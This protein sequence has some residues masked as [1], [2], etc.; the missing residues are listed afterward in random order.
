MQASQPASP[1]S[2]AALSSVS[3]AATYLQKAATP[4]A[5]DERRQKLLAGSPGVLEGKESAVLTPDED[6]AFAFLVAACVL[7]GGEKGGRGGTIAIPL[8]R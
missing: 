1:S 3:D 7:R 2:Q 6:E 4:R 8:P 5:A